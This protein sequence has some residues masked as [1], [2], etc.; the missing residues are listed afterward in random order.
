M[1]HD[2]DHDR[3]SPVSLPPREK[4][5]TVSRPKPDAEKDENPAAEPREPADPKVHP[6][7]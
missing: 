4:P 5:V 2:R 7:R 3:D 6:T 1:T